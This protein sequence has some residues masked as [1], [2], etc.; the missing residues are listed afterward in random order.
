MSDQIEILSVALL[1][2]HRPTVN[3]LKK[4]AHSLG[5]E[6]GWH[7]LLDLTWIIQNLGTIRGKRLMD[8]GAGTGILQWYLAQGGAEV[9]SV[10][11]SSRSELPLHFRRRFYTKGLRQQDLVP[12]SQVIRARLRGQGG[13]AVLERDLLSLPRTK[14]NSGSVIIYNQDLQNL[15]DIP[16]GS[17]DAVGAVSALEHN[18][19]ETL[20]LVVAELTRVLKPGGLLLATLGA[21]RDQDWYHEPSR[22]W[23]YTDASLRRLFD[24]SPTVSSNY[25]QY[26]ELFGALKACTE[27]RSGLAAFYSRSGNN[28]MPW[29]K[30]DPQYQPVGVRKVKN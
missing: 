24:I 6:F 26:D 7:Y 27:L 16:D 4:L 28:G 10:D 1:D 21:A 13:M 23:N 18:P 20:P 14:S 15:A 12:T 8:A 5:L 3:A 17:V 9:L 19:P 29:G 22:G 11:R 2:K 25:A 30:W